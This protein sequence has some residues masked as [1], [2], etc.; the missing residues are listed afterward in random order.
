MKNYLINKYTPAISDTTDCYK[1]KFY[2]NFDGFTQEEVDKA[3]KKLDPERKKILS[4]MFG[5]ND[6]K[7]TARQIKQKYNFNSE[8]NVFYYVNKSIE[9]IKKHLYGTREEVE[10]DFYENFPNFSKEEVDEALSQLESK[11]KNIIISYYGLDGEKLTNKEIC[12]KYKISSVKHYLNRNIKLIN[13]KLSDSQESETKEIVE[14]YQKKFYDYFQNRS[15][16]EIDAAL[17]SLDDETKDIIIDYY[18]LNNVKVRPVDIAVKNEIDASHIRYYLEKG[19]RK[20]KKFLG[21]TYFEKNF[22]QNFLEYTQEEVD[23]ALL[24]IDEK[25]RDILISYFGINGDK[26]EVAKIAKKH[27]FKVK[28]I[29][30]NVERSLNALDKVLKQFNEIPLDVKFYQNFAC[31][32]KEEVDESLEKIDEKVSDILIR[33]YGLRG[34]KERS[35]DIAK[36]HNFAR[37]NINYYLEKGIRE[38]KKNLEKKDGDLEPSISDTKK[39]IEATPSEA[40]I[41]KKEKFYESFAAYSR[42]EIDNALSRIDEKRKGILM[43]YFGLKSP[44]QRTVDIANEYDFSVTSISY[45]IETS[46]NRVRKE[47]EADSKANW[48]SFCEMFKGDSQEDIKDVFAKLETQTREM[49]SFKYGL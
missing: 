43:Q 46:M 9:L 25:S 21:D 27:S 13:M 39:I 42:E 29:E 3:L 15:K 33:Y 47:L 19:I 45:Y 31:Y 14:K 48:D 23:K 30:A 44:R 40:D 37:K 36:K 4:L 10:L 11:A 41:E 49:I 8:I 5:L 26:I 24:E 2:Q 18:G 1:E 35:G 6:D 17:M 22:Y 16:E 12:E 38:I 32:S 34:E 7:L 28:N 20:I